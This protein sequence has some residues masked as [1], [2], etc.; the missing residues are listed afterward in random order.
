MDVRRR[1]YRHF[2]IIVSTV[3]PLIAGCSR[4]MEGNAN[5]L[6]D[7]D[8]PTAYSLELKPGS[9]VVWELDS[10]SVPEFHSSFYNREDSTFYYLSDNDIIRCP[11]G[12]IKAYR[13][14]YGVSFSNFCVRGDSIIGIKYNSNQICCYSSTTK[15]HEWSEPILCN[16]PYPPVPIARVSPLVV[17]D[18]VIMYFGEISGEP[19]DET[20]SNRPTLTVFDRKE[21]KFRYSVG[22]PEVYRKGNWGG[23]ILR[24]VY[25]DFNE[26][27]NSFVIGFPISHFI[28][29]LDIGTKRMERHY[30]GSRKFRVVLPFSNDKSDNPGAREAME[31]VARTDSYAN[32]LYDPWRN[33]YYRIAELSIPD[34]TVLPGFKK[35]ISVIIL[36]KNFKKVGETEIANAGRNFRYG[37]FVSHRGLMVP[38]DTTEDYLAYR[39]YLPSERKLQ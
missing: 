7:E 19:E 8:D 38:V 16:A 6:Y 26:K 21:R 30:A 36:D 39:T 1:P 12:D 15:E 2:G 29:V 33:L 34:K 10:L 31:Y 4:Q 18:S 32:V 20:A 28:D 24:W 3:M 37:T 13:K 27:E 25:S 5:P 23:G 22:Y 11:F 14:D 35:D 17:T 9:P